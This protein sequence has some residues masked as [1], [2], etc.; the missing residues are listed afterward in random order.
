VQ[1]GLQHLLKQGAVLLFGPKISMPF[2]LGLL[3][4]RWGAGQGEKG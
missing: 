1:A 3:T 2:R 4:Y